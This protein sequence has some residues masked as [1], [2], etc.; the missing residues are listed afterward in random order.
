MLLLDLHLMFQAHLFPQHIF[1]RLVEIL[2]QA[3]IAS[4]SYPVLWAMVQIAETEF[5]NS[6]NI[7]LGPK[8]RVIPTREF[9]THLGPASLKL[10]CA[11]LSE[12]GER[13][14]LAVPS[15]SAPPGELK[16]MVC[17]VVYAVLVL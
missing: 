14:Q 16:I 15:M 3:K 10:V 12:T 8:G 13:T 6:L 4:P 7:Y 2:I 11:F 9:Q 5:S 1:F 17:V